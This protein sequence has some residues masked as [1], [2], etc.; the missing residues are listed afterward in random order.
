M[1]PKPPW[2]PADYEPA[3]ISAIQALER[4]EATPDQQK[5]AL[6]WI[7]TDVAGTYDETFFPG[8]DG[9]RNSNFASGKRHVGLNIV[10]ML[11]LNAS[12]MTKQARGGK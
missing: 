4:G 2:M 9:E 3:D 1:K 5:R 10:K 11:K 12:A 7:I 8:E 6:K